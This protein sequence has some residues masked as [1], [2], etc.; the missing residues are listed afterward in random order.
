[1][2]SKKAKNSSKAVDVA[3][4][5]V[6]RAVITAKFHLNVPADF[7]EVWLLAISL[8]ADKPLDAFDA[9]GL[10]L[11]GP[12][13][14]L[15]ADGKPGEEVSDIRWRHWH[16]PMEFTN[17]VQNTKDSRS[18]F[19]YCR[20]DPEQV[21]TWVARAE[22]DHG[23][24]PVAEGL[25][26]AI[27]MHVAKVDK[28]GVKAGAE[29]VKEAAA[30]GAASSNVKAALKAREKAAGR[31]HIETFSGCGLVVPFDVEKDLGYRDYGLNEKELTQL[32]NGINKEM[33]AGKPGKNR[34]EWDELGSC[35]S[36]AND[37]CAFGMGL[38]LGANAYSHGSPI[39]RPESL[40]LM[41]ISYKLL[42]RTPLCDIARSMLQRKAPGDC[43]AALAEGG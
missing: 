40:R 9:W 38:E 25:L 20:D 12:F 35:V 22:S 14:V 18:H 23:F 24:K 27:A 34:E 6:S 28:K 37:E 17:C 4:E 2:I 42:G 5:S 32:L 7:F 26:P 21:P 30:D 13:E 8:N 16:D 15:A 43:P 1:M 29:R 11:V 3:L 41:G 31:K 39:L 19:G 33:E 36:F 10:R